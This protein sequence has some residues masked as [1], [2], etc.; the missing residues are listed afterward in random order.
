MNLDISKNGVNVYACMRT[1][2][3]EWMCVCASVRA[4]VLVQNVNSCIL[5]A[6]V[7]RNET[8]SNSF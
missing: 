7:S 3:H 1:Y 6:V 4:C 2:M 5:F 8:A